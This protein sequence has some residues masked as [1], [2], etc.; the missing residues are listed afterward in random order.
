MLLAAELPAL[1][2]ARLRRVP[3]RGHGDERAGARAL[4]AHR[5]R[6]G[7]RRR[8]RAA[9]ALELAR[10]RLDAARPRD[11]ALH[12]HHAGDARGRAAARGGAAR[13]RAGCCAGGVLV[14][15]SARFDL[16]VLRGAFARAGLDW[17][18]PPVLCTVAMARR[19][20]PLQKRRG[21]ASLADA[22]GIDVEETHR[23]LPDAETC[24]RVFCALF[25]RL[26]AARGDGRRRGRAARAAPRRARTRRPRA[27]AK[28]RPPSERPDFSSLPKDPGVYVFRD[29]DGRPLYVGKSVSLRTRAR[30]HFTTPAAWTGPGR[31]RR[32]P[33]DG[34]RA[35]RAPARGPADQD[36]APAGQQA[37]QAQRRRLRLPA[38]PARHPVPDPRGRARAGERARGHRRAGARPGGGERARRAAQLALRPAPLRPQAA[39]PRAPERLRADGPLPLALPAATSTRTSTAS[40]STRRCGCSSTAATAAAR[41]SPTSTASCAPRWQERHYERAAWLERRRARLDALIAAARR[42]AARDARGRAARARAAPE[43][44][45]PLRRVLDRRRADRRLGPAPARSRGAGDRAP[46]RRCAR[47]RARSSAAGCPRRRSPEM[48]LV[49]AWIAAN[50]PP[51]LELGR[52]PS[53]ATGCGASSRASAAERGVSAAA[54]LREPP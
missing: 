24:A 53:T 14:A 36:D 11:P 35:G 21:L 23:A 42:R 34:V 15:H 5:G 6:R 33:G 8:R 37:R 44:P 40:G 20:A 17:P 48:R 2:A 52:R 41:C 29:A 12:R 25:P 39:A 46:P 43:R 26:I 3:R 38:L 1:P 27:G 4:R 10:R 18:Q 51:V 49:G 50:A 54:G 32:L 22:L 9:R 7:A 28:R 16:G 13:A 47:R 30:Q 19:F 31:A 45:R